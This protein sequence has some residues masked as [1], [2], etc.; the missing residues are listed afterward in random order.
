M[1]LQCF[2][3]HVYCVMCYRKGSVIVDYSLWVD[4][5]ITDKN[6]LTKILAQQT[7]KIGGSEVDRDSIKYAGRFDVPIKTL[8]RYIPEYLQTI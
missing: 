7:F 3:N 2:N 8:H 5:T 1:S 6:V 4:D